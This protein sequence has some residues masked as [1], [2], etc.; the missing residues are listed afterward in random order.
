[1][2]KISHRYQGQFYIISSK[3]EFVVSQNLLFTD[4]NFRF[5]MYNHLRKYFKQ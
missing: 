1:M 4:I 3:I 5:R 2:F